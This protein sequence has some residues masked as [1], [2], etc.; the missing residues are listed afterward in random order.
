MT[1]NYKDEVQEQLPA[2]STQV[3]LAGTVNSAHIVY[4]TV[5]NEDTATNVTITVN[6]VQS[7]GSA[8]LTNQYVS[9]PVPAGASLVLNEL[10]GRV[11]KTGDAIYA[12]A[13]AA[14]SLNLSV[15][16]KEITS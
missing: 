11:L 7:G 3:Y 10:L 12:T 9:R 14:N 5:H 4:A 15:G 2:T 13:G 6:V 16:I 8:G 1:T